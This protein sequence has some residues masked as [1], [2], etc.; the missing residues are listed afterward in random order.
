MKKLLLLLALATLASAC[1]VSLNGV[2]HECGIYADDHLV[3]CVPI[4][5]AGNF[6]SAPRP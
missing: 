4:L 3:H 1:Q 5:P 2:L 6:K